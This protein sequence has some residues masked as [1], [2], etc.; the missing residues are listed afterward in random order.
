MLLKS[1]ITCSFTSIG[2]L[3]Y[4]L[5][6]KMILWCAWAWDLFMWSWFYIY[7]FK[8]S[9]RR[10]LG[11][12]ARIELGCF[13]R[14]DRSEYSILT[15]EDARE[16]KMS[17]TRVRRKAL[18]MPH[19]ARPCAASRPTPRAPA[20]AAPHHC[21]GVEGRRDGGLTH[22][23]V[24]RCHGDGQRWWDHPWVE[25]SGRRRWRVVA[26]PPMWQRSDLKRG[27]RW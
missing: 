4:C 14:H 9:P 15:W 12:L 1:S 10:R 18:R 23:G 19:A 27:C 16:E 7:V 6:L 24:G 13:G 5:N 8:A 21:E 17:R 26:P 2:N 22:G 20:P 11:I 3:L 25:W